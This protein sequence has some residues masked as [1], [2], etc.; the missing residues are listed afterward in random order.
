MSTIVEYANFLNVRPSELLNS[1]AT[2]ATLSDQIAA[3]LSNSRELE[4]EL[5]GAVDTS[6]AGTLIPLYLET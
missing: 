6:K 3:L 5:R 1:I 4:D 2:D